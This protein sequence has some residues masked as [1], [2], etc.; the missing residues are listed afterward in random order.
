M[1]T[2][3]IDILANVLL[4]EHEAVATAG[5]SEGFMGGGL[6]AAFAAKYPEARMYV[7]DEVDTRYGGLLPVGDCIPVLLSRTAKP[8]WLLYCPTTVEPKRFVAGR[9][10][11]L[12][13]CAAIR[14]AKLLE[15][16]SLALP[17]FCT[18]YGNLSETES[19]KQIEEAIGE[20]C[21]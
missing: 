7:R 4:A 18:G 17:L 21:V 19:R 6:D 5:N 8:K 3:H 2:L 11:F 13:A 16:K 20:S 14:M 1:T 12:A 9:N 10:A 15:V